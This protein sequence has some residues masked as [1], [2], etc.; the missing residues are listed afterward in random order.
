M[1]DTEELCRKNTQ[2]RKDILFPCHSLDDK[3]RKS[4]QDPNPFCEYKEQGGIPDSRKNKETAWRNC[5]PW[6]Y[7][8][9]H[10]SMSKKDCHDT[11]TVEATEGHHVLMGVSLIALMNEAV[12]QPGRAL[13]SPTKWVRAKKDRVSGF[14]KSSRTMHSPLFPNAATS[15]YHEKAYSIE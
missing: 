8:N 9:T 12:K 7:E 6:R 15:N 10:L 5:L 1:S 2:P 3:R 11:D 14:R 13:Q 4:P